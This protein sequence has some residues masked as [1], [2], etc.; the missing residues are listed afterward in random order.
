M[1]CLVERMAGANCA[2]PPLYLI[3]VTGIIG[4]MGGVWAGRRRKCFLWVGLS[5][6]TRALPLGIILGC[7][8]HLLSIRLLLRKA[9]LSPRIDQTSYE[10]DE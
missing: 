10:Q 6:L 2:R 4:G 1:G 5:S 3:V 7:E 9:F 8:C